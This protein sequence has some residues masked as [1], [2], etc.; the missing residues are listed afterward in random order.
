[1]EGGSASPAGGGGRMPDRAGAALPSLPRWWMMW[2]TRPP[3]AWPASAP[4]LSTSSRC[5]VI[6]SA[7][8]AP[9]KPASGATGA[10]PLPP[11]PHAAVSAAGV[12]SASPGRQG[13]DA[14]RAV[15][16]LPCTHGTCRG[17][18]SPLRARHLD[19]LQRSQFGAR[20]SQQEA[21]K[22]LI[23]LL[24]TIIYDV[25][26]ME[27]SSHVLPPPMVALTPPCPHRASGGGL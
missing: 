21:K 22:L 9:R 25:V 19:F 1:M 24:P 14:G 26:A 10:T 15:L 11:P 17:G 23:F 18:P 3:A 8:T 4:A 27:G 13:G 6:P 2:A 12:G 5:A 20:L 7:S 16:P